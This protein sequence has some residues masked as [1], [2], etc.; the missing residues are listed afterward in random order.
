LPLVDRA[1]SNCQQLESALGGRSPKLEL[2]V[3][4]D[5]LEILA[6]WRVGAFASKSSARAAVEICR[7]DNQVTRL[8]F[9][10][11]LDLENGGQ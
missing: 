9:F 8:A 11:N 5:G 1:P 6:R 3:C 10:V 4:G 7:S 2:R